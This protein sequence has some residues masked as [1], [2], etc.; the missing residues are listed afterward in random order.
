MVTSH[1]RLLQTT[2]LHMHLLGYDYLADCPTTRHGLTRLVPVIDAA[3]NEDV[4]TLLFDNGDFLQG[5]PLADHI[6]RHGPTKAPHPAIEAFNALQYDAIT[7]GNHEFDYGL[8]FLNEALADCEMPVVSAN[9]RLSPTRN[10]V[11]PWT[12]LVRDVV[13][14]DGNRYQLKIGVIGFVTPQVVDW[15]AHALGGAI[16]TDDILTAARSHLPALRRAGADIVVALCH[17]GISDAGYVRGMENAALHLAALPGIDVVFAGHT[18]D[19]FPGADFAGLANADTDAATLHGKPAV[20][21][22]AYGRALGVVDLDLRL[23]PDGWQIGGHHVALRDL[24]ASAAIPATPIGARIADHAA[25]DQAD[26]LDHLGEVLCET[27]RRITSFFAALGRDGTAPLVASAQI[28]HLKQALAGTDFEGLPILAT[29]SPHRAGGHGGPQNY[30]DI[31]AGHI[32]RRHVA[33]IVPFDNPMCGVLRRGW[34]I[35]TWLEN[36]AWFYNVLTPGGTNQSLINP[37]FPAYHFDQIH[38]LRYRID[39]TVAP[40]ANHDSSRPSRVRDITFNGAPL[41]DDALFV[42]ATNSYRAHG[43]GDLADIPTQDIIY[44]S[45][46]GLPQILINCMTMNGIAANPPDPNIG[47]MAPPGTQAVFATSPGAADVPSPCAR[48]RQGGLTGEK[49]QFLNMLLDL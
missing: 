17:A 6:A 30:V 42:V 31:P 1:L 40:R 18:H 47:F 21:A 32:R 11:A 13:G 37:N 33:A 44:S 12:V 16:Q 9:V 23:D 49:P 19:R 45:V 24:K 39:L 48:L 38:G 22:G 34:Q 46:D 27:P 4:T 41:A 36:A 20:M 15:N 7:L 8:K 35:R 43:G 10:L 28:N 3:R 2:D 26:T 5:N 14:S 25:R 29:T